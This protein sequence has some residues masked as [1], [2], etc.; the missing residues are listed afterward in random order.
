[1]QNFHY[2]KVEL[3]CFI[4]KLVVVKIVVKS[5]KTPKLKFYTQNYLCCITDDFQISEF[6]E[7]RKSTALNEMTASAAGAC[8]V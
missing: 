2:T 6:E 8:F 3:N 5:S 7:K 1:M 4:W